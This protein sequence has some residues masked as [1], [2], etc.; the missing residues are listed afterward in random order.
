[1]REAIW[2]PGQKARVVLAAA[3]YFRLGVAHVLGGYDLLLFL[4][5]LTL[6]SRGWI[7]LL[8]II[9][10]FTAAHSATLALAA[11][12]SLPIPGRLAGVLVSASIAYV[13]AENLFPDYAM[14]RRWTVSLCSGLA[15]GLAFAQGLREIGLPRDHVAMSL[16]NFNLGVEAA[17]AIVLLLL[18]PVLAL[19]RGKP[20]ESKLIAII[21]A[22]V[23]AVGLFH[24][25]D[26]ALFG[27]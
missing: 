13:A 9:L 7:P 24:F 19:I 20:W 5:V 12:A 25:V 2:L 4:L 26:R 16:L 15:H 14:A 21:S 27:I 17:Q 18:L 1:M 11:L 23:L 22:M 8:G 3:S 10:T 6:R